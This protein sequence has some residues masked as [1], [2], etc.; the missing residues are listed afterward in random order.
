MYKLN[1]VSAIKK[2][3]NKELRD[4]ICKNYYSQIGFT[5]KAVI[6]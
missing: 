3:T 4:L 1:I 5:K 6:I 2:M